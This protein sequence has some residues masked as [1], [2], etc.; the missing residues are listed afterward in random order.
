MFAD[1]LQEWQNQKLSNFQKF[2]LSAQTSAALIHT[3]LCQA[4]LIEDLFADGYEYVLTAKFQGDTL[5]KRYWQYRQLSGGRFLVSMKDVSRSENILKIKSLVKEGFNIDQSLKVDNV[6]NEAVQQFLKDV[7][8]VIP[9]PDSIQLH[10]N[11]KEVS[12]N[13]AGYIARKSKKL[14][15]NCCGEDIKSD[16]E[17]QATYISILSRGGLITPSEP[18]SN[19]VSRAFG[20]LD[21][22]SVFIR[23]SGLP[24]KRAGFEI[25]KKYLDTD[26]IACS[27]H[28]ALFSNRLMCTVC[29]C[30]FDAQRKRSNENVTVE[31]RTCSHIF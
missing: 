29:N 28:S 19:A 15:L 22:T 14:L 21:A 11:T 10:P 1:W 13:V 16:K 24:S 18:L 27:T 5:E 25:L 8:L 12:D 20:L 23:K 6:E 31:P 26:G 30:F 4:A 2:T 3:T 7:E 17:P 9:D